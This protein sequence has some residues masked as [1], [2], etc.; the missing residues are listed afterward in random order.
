MEIRLGEA[1]PILTALRWQDSIRDSCAWGD[2]R[3]SQGFALLCPGVVY[4]FLSL[5][6]HRLKPVTGADRLSLRSWEERGW[7]KFIPEELFNPCLRK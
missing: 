4:L 2:M 5:F 1:Q 7:Y 3:D 6:I